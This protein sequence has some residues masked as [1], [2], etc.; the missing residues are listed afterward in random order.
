MHQFHPRE[1]GDDSV[2]Q[3]FES[4]MGSAGHRNR[5]P[6]ARRSDDPEEIHLFEGP[7]VEHIAAWLAEPAA[8]SNGRERIVWIGAQ[9]LVRDVGD[10]VRISDRVL[11]HVATFELDGMCRV[12]V[13]CD[14]RHHGEFS[15]LITAGTPSTAGDAKWEDGSS[16]GPSALLLCWH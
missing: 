14:Q 8:Y 2:E 12:H 10:V 7:Q 5:T 11:S 16:V 15:S 1:A 3:I 13:A 9:R 6:V 4:R